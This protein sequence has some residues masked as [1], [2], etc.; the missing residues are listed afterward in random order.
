MQRRPPPQEV[1]RRRPRP[2]RRGR[3]HS[4]RSSRRPA[5]RGSGVFLGCLLPGC[6]WWSLR[7][8]RRRRQSLSWGPLP[9]RAPPPLPLEPRCWRRLP[10]SPAQPPPPHLP[11]AASRPLQR[12]LDPCRPLR[13]VLHLQWARPPRRRPRAAAQ[14]RRRLAPQCPVGCRSPHR[15][16]ARPGWRWPFPSCGASMLHH[17]CPYRSTASTWRTPASSSR[18]PLRR[19][20]AP[21]PGGSPWSARRLPRTCRRSRRRHRPRCR[22]RAAP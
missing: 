15:F 9:L 22:W 17:P 5:R 14:H 2:P 7:W 3:V 20:G 12:E 19:P 21:P 18:P 13:Q 1:P 11:A 6:L 4:S 8:T 16:A 10:L